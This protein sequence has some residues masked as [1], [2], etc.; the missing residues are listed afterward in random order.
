[1][2]EYLSIETGI[3]TISLHNQISLERILVE[4]HGFTWA[5]GIFQSL[6]PGVYGEMAVG[7]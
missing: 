1:M 6:I 3:H 2:Y 4:N 5:S 7:L